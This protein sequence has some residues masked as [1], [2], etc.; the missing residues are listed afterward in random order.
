[1]AD[2]GDELPEHGNALLL[3][4]HRECLLASAHQFGQV[5][6]GDAIQAQ[7]FRLVAFH[8]LLV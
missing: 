6:D 5:P 2:V 7:Q 1:M 3:Q 4:T 8:A